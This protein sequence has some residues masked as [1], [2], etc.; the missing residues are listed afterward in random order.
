MLGD[1]V[2]G[3]ASR[4]MGPRGAD[5]RPGPRR[6][7]RRSHLPDG[8]HAA[9]QSPDSDYKKACFDAYNL[10]I[11]EYCAAHPDRLI[12]TGQTAMRSAEEGIADLQ[13]D[14]GR[15]A[16]KRRDDAG[17][18]AGRGLRQPDLRSSSGRPRST[19]DAAQLPHPDQP[20][21]R[22]WPRPRA[23][24]QQLHVDHPR[25]PGHHRHAHLRRRLRAPS[26]AARW[27][28]SRRTPAGRR[29]TCTAWTTPTTAIATG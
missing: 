9:L 22:G 13:R 17:Q 11:A 1:Q 23:Q 6:R 10:W 3:P 21:R 2:R 12:G 14:Q 27:C 28:A 26:Q 24:A 8:R 18:S 25:Q 15:W 20:R 7:R 19:R 16:C 5:G 29:T 4:R